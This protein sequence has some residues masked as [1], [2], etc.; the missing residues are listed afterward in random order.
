MEEAATETSQTAG[1]E[2]TQT[3]GTE[4]TGG[5]AV[6]KETSN[7]DEPFI[8]PKELPA[9][10]QGHFKRM[11]RSFTKKM[12][13]AK[14]FEQ[15]AKMVDE[16]YRDPVGSMQRLAQQYG[17]QIIPPGQNSARGEP[18]QGKEWRPQNW[19][20]VEERISSKAKQIAE[21]DI[22][23]R[24]GPVFNEVMAIKRNHIETILDDEYPA[25]REHEDEM[26]SLV[27]AHPTLANDPEKLVRLV[28][29]KE[30]IEGRAMQKALKKLNDKRE[31]GKIGSGSPAKSTE[32][33]SGKKLTFAESVE[34]ARRTLKS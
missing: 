3:A 21:K 8:D 20:E 27:Q 13:S 30:E 26:A 4:G 32:T 2:E 15:K 10:L 28:I 29:P 33:K 23:D 1:T 22:M 12:Q 14:G 6:S 34:E 19:G 24:L 18:E 25:W 16:F 11:Q 31:A 9:E 5:K 17:Y 7:T